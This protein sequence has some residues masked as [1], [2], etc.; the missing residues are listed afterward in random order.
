M[1]IDHSPLQ[2]EFIAFW[3]ETFVDDTHR[4]DTF[5]EYLRSEWY[6]VPAGANGP[7]LLRGQFPT[8]LPDDAVA[9]SIKP[10]IETAIQEHR[11]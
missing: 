10:A 11:I 4:Y 5:I 3:F 7:I 6:T 1:R 9:D 2:N 8:S